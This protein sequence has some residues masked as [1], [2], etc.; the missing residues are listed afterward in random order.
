MGNGNHS[1]KGKRIFVDEQR[2]GPYSLWHQ[3]FN[4]TIPG[5]VSMED[6]VDYK[7]PLAKVLKNTL[8]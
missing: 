4:K 8:F 7:L 1:R 6:I 5:G 2:F 3:Y